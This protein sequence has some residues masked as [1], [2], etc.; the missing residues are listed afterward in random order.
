MF[1]VVVSL[2]EVF[3]HTP[4][5]WARLKQSEILTSMVVRV[6][7]G[8]R[9]PSSLLKKKSVAVMRAIACE[10]HSSVPDPIDLHRYRNKKTI[11]AQG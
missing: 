9:D 3:V 1:G 10:R 2:L 4:A 6:Q 8:E 11:A 7:D 5:F